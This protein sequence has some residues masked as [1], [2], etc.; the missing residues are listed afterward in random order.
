MQLDGGFSKL[1]L[2]ACESCQ[3]ALGYHGWSQ[4]EEFRMAWKWVKRN[5]VVEK[6]LIDLR[7][8]LCL[9]FNKLGITYVYTQYN[10]INAQIKISRNAQLPTSLE[11]FS[12]GVYVVHYVTI[13][14]WVLRSF[15]LWNI[16]H[17]QVN[18]T[19]Q[20]FHPADNDKFLCSISLRIAMQYLNSTTNNS[21]KLWRWAI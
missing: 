9:N 11:R 1:F 8:F 10:K 20:D 16:W 7:S 12:R 4:V 17:W 15:Y 14:K 2:N 5:V 21:Q 18:D 13:K 3:S 6:S 19:W